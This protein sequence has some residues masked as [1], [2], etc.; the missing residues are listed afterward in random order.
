LSNRFSPALPDPTQ[1]LLVRAA[2]GEAPAACSAWAHWRAAGGKLDTIDPSAV[3]LLP[4]IYRNLETNRVDD[5]DFLRLKG[6]YRH[7]WVTNHGVASRL[8]ETLEALTCEDIPTMV[9]GG[10]AVSVTHYR[11]AG[12]RHLDDAGVLVPA[13][14]AH[15]ALASLRAVGWSSPSGI[16]DVR[17]V[18]SRHA[19]ALILPSRE[20]L[21]VHW[22]VLPE[23]IGDDDFWSAAVPVTV[24]RAATLAPGPTQQLLHTCA[25]GVR[26]G[27]DA[28]TW[29]ADAAVIIR[30]S[31]AGIDWERFVAGAAARRV[32]LATGTSL[33]MLRTVLDLPIRAQITDQ[34]HALP[35]TARERLLL[36]LARNPGPVLR[37]AQL[38]DR[39]RRC[40]AAPADGGYVY[41]DFL[42]YVA[43]AT[44]VPSRRAL[45]VRVARRALALGGVTAP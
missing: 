22:R 5:P 1:L 16:D 23:S 9:L 12:A 44:D 19:V 25:D 36:A 4:S 37:C 20:P 26:S 32:A 39:Y 43:D 18:R 17:I 35:E 8:G 33:A 41:R 34:L 38:W 10:A 24:G 29:M 2:A 7:A 3:R 27:P 30:R 42:K 31:G 21:H 13:A 14:Q 11:D 40:A 15:H 45:A 6:V 28:L